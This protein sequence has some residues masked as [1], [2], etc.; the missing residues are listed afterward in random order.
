MNVTELARK[1][2]IPTK[3]LL[4]ILPEVGFDIGKKA[5]KIND[6][7]A[8]KIVREWPRLYAGY[9]EKFKKQE[10]AEVQA[11]TAQKK[12]PLPEYATIRDFAQRAGIPVTRVL[13]ALMKNGMLLSMNEKID[14]DTASIISSELGIELEKET[15]HKDALEEHAPTPMTAAESRE[16]L[17]PRPPVIVIMGHVDHGKTKLLDAIRKSNVAAEESGGITQHIGAYQIIRNNK[18]ITFIDT[19]GHEAFTTMRS[20][21][22]RIADIAILVIA[23]DDGMKPQ[24]KESIRIIQS[25]NIPM[26]VAINKIDKPE[27]NIEKVKQELA[28]E[29]LLPEDWGG[30]TVCQPI[31]AKTGTGIHELLDTIVLVGEMEKDKI[32]A[33]P[34]AAAG[35][36]V[37]ESH[38]DQGEG[39]VA[40]ALIQNGT[41][42]PGDLVFVND[43]FYGKVRGLKNFLGKTIPAAPPSMPVKILGLKGIPSIG[44]ILS[45]K[46]TADRKSKIK[47]YQ[48]KTQAASVYAPVS[49]KEKKMGSET[50]NVI[51]RTDVL[52]SLEAIT[53]SLD[54]LENPYVRLNII[55][56]GLGNVTENDVLL[57]ESNHAIILGFHSVPSPAAQSLAQEKNIEIKLFKIIYEL[58][59]E[60]KKLMEE[61][62]KPNIERII[63]GKLVIL[64]VF[65]KEKQS[66]VIGGRVASGK[67]VLG[68]KA[69]V[70]RE[71]EKKSSGKIIKLQI[72]KVDVNEVGQGH[73][74]GIQYEGKP[75]ILEGDTLELYREEV[76]QKKLG[77]KDA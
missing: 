59:D 29:N 38:V 44:D 52:G 67:A 22:A 13:T 49:K 25:A 50:F 35:G 54:K 56:R 18:A 72:N 39:S 5:I 60:V 32:C 10:K 61:K 11:E 34:D 62:I 3:E 71:N 48:L 15:M 40:T 4:E 16:S 8:Q 76:T 20:R 7:I 73:E 14:F 47:S 70:M 17:S 26:I 21:G 24:T 41:L 74:C 51:L 2:K 36:T 30:K 46:K 33:N 63:L 45:V 77:N 57:A 66:M 68:V 1:L 6:S 43:I 9:K 31:S 64:K 42:R 23:A 28:Q 12:I 53:S 65:K 58:L 69:D 27:A 75:I 55:G 19:P 37:I